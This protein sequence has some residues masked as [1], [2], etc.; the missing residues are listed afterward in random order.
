MRQDV[1]PGPP[2]RRTRRKTSQLKSHVV[3]KAH[4]PVDLEHLLVL[5]VERQPGEKWVDQHVGVAI[6][7]HVV[8]VV[9]IDDDQT[10]RAIR[11]T[12]PA[13]PL[14]LHKAG[15]VLGS[16]VLD[17]AHDIGGVVAHLQHRRGYREVVTGSHRHAAAHRLDA[18]RSRYPTLSHEPPTLTDLE[19]AAVGVRGRIALKTL[20]AVGCRT[21]PVGLKK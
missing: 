16:H 4:D 11:G 3:E 7:M 8:G 20:G 12:A 21:G 2:G 19:Q 13:T 15:D 14:S 10:D 6:E 1:S 5:H 18:Q 17:Y 9:G